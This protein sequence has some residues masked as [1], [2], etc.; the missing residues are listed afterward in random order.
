MKRDQPRLPKE[1]AENDEEEERHESVVDPGASAK[2]PGPEVQA[3]RG[4]PEFQEARG[5]CRV[6]QP[7]RGD[8]RQEQQETGCGLDLQ[9]PRNRLALELKRELV[10]G[11]LRDLRRAALP[12]AGALGG[13]IVPASLYLAVMNGQPG[14][15]GWG[16]VMATDTAFVVGCLGLAPLPS[17]PCDLR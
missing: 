12:F 8:G 14:A 7:Q 9:K 3:N 1:R 5:P 6:R 15:Q 11:E 17:V 4:L 16:T 2:L 10:L 13:M